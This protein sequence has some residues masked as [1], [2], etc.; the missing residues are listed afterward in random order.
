MR[1]C[2]ADQCELGDAIRRALR[3]DPP[4]ASSAEI[5]RPHLRERREGVPASQTRW[6]RPRRR[7]GAALTLSRA[8]SRALSDAEWLQHSPDGDVV[9]A[10]GHRARG[11]SEGDRAAPTLWRQAAPEHPTP[12]GDPSFRSTRQFQG[13]SWPTATGPAGTWR[14]RRPARSVALPL[15]RADS[16]SRFAKEA[17]KKRPELATGREVGGYRARTSWVKAEGAV[18]DA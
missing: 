4:T 9:H 14:G 5:V 12:A 8:A 15:E 16:G 1:S 13:N 11:A 18:Y 10:A 6:Q 7:R 17:V 3:E 2:C